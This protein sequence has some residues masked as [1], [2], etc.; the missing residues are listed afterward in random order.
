MGLRW[1][2][3]FRF[4]FKMEWG[5][6]VPT[7]LSRGVDPPLSMEDYVDTCLLH[8]RLCRYMPSKK[9]ETTIH[10]HEKYI[11]AHHVQLL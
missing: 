8:G 7:P 6:N 5:Q 4:P 11:L 9:I 1:D 3:W 2:G 10:H